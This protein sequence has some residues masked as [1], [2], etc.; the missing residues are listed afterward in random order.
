MID[1]SDVSKR[2]GTQVILQD[3]SFQI[4][5]GEQ[6]GLV[7][8]NGTGKS[9]IASL[10]AGD[11][12][13]DSGQITLPTSARI[14]FLRQQIEPDLLQ[15]PLL[16]YTES[17]ARDL[18]RIES[19][20]YALQTQLPNATGAQRTDLMETLGELQ[21]AFEHAG[22]Y[23]R[24]HRAEA[25]LDGLGFPTPDHQK[26]LQSF[27]GGWQMRASLARTLIAD[28]DIL[29]LDEPSNYLD[30]PAV[31]WLQRFLRE[32][33]G[34]LLLISH[35]RYLLN[36]LTS[37]TVECANAK[38]DR[39]VGNYDTYLQVRAM[40]SE[41]QASA[42]RNME[43]KREKA[44]QFISRFRYKATKASQVKSR[45][46]MLERMEPAETGPAHIV[47]RGTIRIPRPP[48]AGQEI[49][50][51]DQVGFSYDNQRWVLRHLDLQIQ[52]GEKIAIVGHN[53][54][55]KTTLLRLLA[56][57]LAPGEGRRVTGYHV[58]QGYQSQ[59]FTDTMQPQNTVW[60]TVKQVSGTMPEQALRTLLGGFGFP[61]T[62]IEKTVAVLSGG[63]KVRL[64]FARLLANPPNFLLL[65]EPTTHLDIATR[66][67]LETALQA[68]EGTLCL[69]SHDVTFVENVASQVIVMRPPGIERFPG[70]YSEY[71]AR[72]AEKVDLAPA[73][74]VA[75]NTTTTAQSP[76][77][78]RRLRAE[79][80]MATQ[81]EIRQLR[82][83]LS[84]AEKQIGIFEAEQ[85]ALLAQIAA[86]PE[87]FDFEDANRRLTTIQQEIATYTRRWEEAATRLEALDA[88]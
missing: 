64:A 51:L 37:I 79:E 25:A 40:R 6:A 12:A 68:Y 43:R 69:V 66:E 67:A 76:K 36:S 18:A 87:P 26:L 39:Y 5:P 7:G 53:G 42:Q 84:Q 1:F 62:A 82:R 71:R 59:E 13:P 83:T 60:E 8:P 75:P 46:K 31:E 44:E 27:S 41:S 47:Q 50:R 57:M 72:L 11:L 32:Y 52:R 49:V 77:E 20:M 80:R 10:I 22:G 24:R 16:A 81:K 35:D 3:A 86:P 88:A 48:R 61:G 21:T 55:G 2:F 15:M 14:G 54:L 70:T 73:P 78:R 19:R 85:Q 74:A 28:P 33:Q 45:E 30:L 29:L 58:V 38:T 23:E 65:D 4:H 34:T 9:T 63:E 17:G 56:G